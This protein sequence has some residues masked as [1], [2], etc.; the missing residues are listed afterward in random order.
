MNIRFNVFSLAFLLSTTVIAETAMPYGIAPLN[1]EIRLL[2]R[3]GFESSC[4][5]SVANDKS[6]APLAIKTA[7]TLD[8]AGRFNYRYTMDDSTAIFGV[9]ADGS[10]LNLDSIHFSNTDTE[11]NDQLANLVK[12]TPPGFGVIG[13]RLQQGTEIPSID[14]C[15]TIPGGSSN[16]FSSVS[17]KVAGTVFIRGRDNLIIVSKIKTSCTISNIGKLTFIGEGWEAFDLK[18]GL[19]S[20]SDIAVKMTMPNSPEIDMKMK[21]SCIISENSNATSSSSFPGSSGKSTEQRLIELKSLMD[22]GLINKEQYEQK[23]TDILKSL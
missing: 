10:G 14:L 16:L 15:K 20:E 4:T 3:P 2:F 6:D 21:N 12:L 18:S 7:L 5:I 23:R 1:G 8:S 22:K 13:N 11:K 17:R 19:S 9:N